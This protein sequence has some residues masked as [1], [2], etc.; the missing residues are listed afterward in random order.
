MLCLYDGIKQAEVEALYSA[1]FDGAANTVGFSDEKGVIH[2]FSLLWRQPS[3]FSGGKFVVISKDNYAPQISLADSEDN[4]TTGDSE[5]TLL[6]DY[7][8]KAIFRLL[9]LNSDNV[10]HKE[11]FI[12][13]TALAFNYLM[14]TDPGLAFAFQSLSP[15]ELAEAAATS[16]YQSQPEGVY[17]LEYEE[18][19]SWMIST[20]FDPLR[21]LLIQAMQVGLDKNILISSPSASHDARLRRT[22]SRTHLDLADCYD[23]GKVQAFVGLC[24][25]KLAMSTDTVI[26]IID[27]ISQ[28]PRSSRNVISKDVV[29]ALL[30]ENVDD[31]QV[32]NEDISYLLLTFLDVLHLSNK[33]FCPSGHFIALL[34]ILAPQQSEDLFRSVHQYYEDSH[35]SGHE[36]VLYMHLHM[37]LRLL[38]YFNSSFGSVAG[39][40]AESLAQAVY[41]KVLLSAE[42]NR[43]SWGKLT[44]FEFIEVFVNGLKICLEIL[45][46][47]NGFFND[48][49]TSL[50][51]YV[52]SSPIAPVMQSAEVSPGL[53]DDQIAS[54]FVG[55][56]G[57]AISVTEAREAL[58]LYEYTS[59]DVVKYL[60]QL[61]DEDQNISHLVFQR[62]VMKL[63]GEHY[64]SQSV[65]QR[66]VADFILD[67]L[68]A[69]L[70]L[71]DDGVF[72][73][74][75]LCIALLLFTEDDD[76]DRGLVALAL[77]RHKV[78]KF[79]AV[80]HVSEV[81]L[82]TCYA[83]CPWEKPEN[84]VSKATADAAEYCMAQFMSEQSGGNTDPNSVVFSNA[85]FVSLVNTL[86]MYL[87]EVSEV[88][89]ANSDAEIKREEGDEYGSSQEEDEDHEEAEPT[90]GDVK[91][92]SDSDEEENPFLNDKE[93]P[94][95]A[96]VL[97][98][99]AAS[100]ILGLEHYKPDDLIDKLGGL[101][102]AGKLN[103]KSWSKWF[104]RTIHKVQ[105]TEADV[106]IAMHLGNRIFN[107]FAS[108]DKESVT[109]ADICPGLALLC[110]EAPLEE[111]LMVAFTVVDDDSDGFISFDQLVQLA[112]SV[113]TVV[114][115]CSRLAMS[116]VTT[117]EFSI[118][119]LSIAAAK[120]GF[121][122]ANLKEI[123]E[124]S[125][126][127]FNDLADD[128]LK[129]ACVM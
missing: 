103:A 73:V 67:R 81:L 77:V 4:V 95:S 102:H 129:L 32:S 107:A 108:K 124:I 44:L 15:K 97:E 50:V 101:C 40:S 74:L 57:A 25:D 36:I 13:V 104:S 47:S 126:E 91:S 22:K 92:F 112:K 3:A 71:G 109:F 118:E 115:M 45:Y 14:E 12:Q 23:N 70:D 94:P 24:R 60:M 76:Y 120:E 93:F 8:V 98:L 88:R 86:L 53:E 121:H 43:K 20:G 79:S 84:F 75:D 19:Y 119:E 65:L 99:R 21:D 52:P 116:K 48:L 82:R 87:D 106:D 16:C 96:T 31:D 54:V 128:F 61:S 66:S 29:L 35:G 100:C 6:T 28:L 30:L 42:V 37:T 105:L 58:G 85:Q 83:L 46:L 117:L 18:F 90:S 27:Y 56:S 63:I 7:K 72:P 127:T 125:L 17:Y 69:T 49:F 113:L 2:P 9:D 114:V 110:S 38:F 34:A 51:G 78:L 41:I 59:Y 89:R 80:R 62:G 122:A 68:V 39:C 33:P 64:V 10:I 26:G 55:Y 5:S 1:S 123:E 11:E 111:R